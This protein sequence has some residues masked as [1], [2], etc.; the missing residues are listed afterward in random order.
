MNAIEGDRFSGRSRLFSLGAVVATPG[1]MNS[2]AAAGLSPSSLLARHACGDWGEVS[3]ADALANDAAVNG[4]D[5]LLSAYVLATGERL[6]VISE[7]DRSVTTLL[8][9][10][11]Y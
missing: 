1:A 4:G 5:R 6:W 2:L 10:A 11:E 9:P 3:A 8:L 7:A